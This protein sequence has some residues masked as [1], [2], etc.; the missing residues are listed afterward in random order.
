VLGLFV[1]RWREPRL[2]R[3][4]KT[5]A[6][7]LTP[8]IYLS[9]TGWI[10]IYALIHRPIEGVFGLALIAS[11]FVIYFIAKKFERTKTGCSNIGAN[12]D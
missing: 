2:N 1:L 10:L 9:L 4:Y 5:F 8:L 11:G 3:P 12:L 7:P 6:F